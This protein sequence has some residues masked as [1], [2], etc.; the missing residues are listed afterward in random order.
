VPIAA[1]RDE[2]FVLTADTLCADRALV[3]GACES[4]GFR[5]RVGAHCDDPATTQGL[6]AAGV[7]IAALPELALPSL[8]ADVVL[9]PFAEPLRR[10]VVA[11]VPKDAPPRRGRDELVAALARAG[12][13]WRSPAVPQRR[14]APSGDQPRAVARR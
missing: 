6:V 12:G 9:R 5:P 13:A 10:R 7:G 2:P 8:R 3:L 11:L 1:T 4:A 14:A